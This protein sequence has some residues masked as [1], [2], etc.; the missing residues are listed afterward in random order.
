M[1]IIHVE[2]DPGVFAIWVVDL[3]SGQAQLAEEV[4]YR[5]GDDDSEWDAEEWASWQA[6]TLKARHKAKSIEWRG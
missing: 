5:W 6:R 3:A 1:T 2:H 4:D